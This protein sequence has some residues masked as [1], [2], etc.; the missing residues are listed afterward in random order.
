MS[1]Q[2]EITRIADNVDDALSAIAAKGVTVPSGANSD[3]MATL[4][5][6]IST[7]GN[8]QSKT[9]IVPTTSSQ[10]ILPDAGY[11]ALSSVQI[12][13]MVVYDGTVV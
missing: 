4:I 7:A 1:I 10:T 5:G 6:Q 3:D 11:D 12:D 8:Y 2:S 13:A 9:G